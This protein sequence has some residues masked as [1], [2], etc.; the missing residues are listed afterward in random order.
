MIKRNSPQHI[1]VHS[2]AFTF[3]ETI[4]VLAVF[5]VVMLALMETIVTF[6]R[7][8]TYTIAQAYQ[9]DHARRGVEQLVR[10]MR[11]MT[12]S[13]NG[14]FPLVLRE[15]YRVGF[16]SDIDRDSSVEYVEYR[17]SS[18][19]LEKRIYSATGTPPTYSTTTP[20]STLTISEYVQNQI[21][22]APIFVYYDKNGVQATSTT[23]TINIAYAQVSVIVNIDPIRDPGQYMLRSSASLR[24]LNH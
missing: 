17:L 8:N 19:T 7:L 2:R 20:E 16:Y 11:E 24:N 1:R 14:A 9:V 6:Y 22:S 21:Q 10:D 13:D 15:S 18:T 4:V 5:T 23:P 12:Y 3:V